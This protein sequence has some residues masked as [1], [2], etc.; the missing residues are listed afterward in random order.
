MK[1]NM[2]KCLKLIVALFCVNIM[3]ASL[4]ANNI[5][6]YSNSKLSSINANYSRSKSSTIKFKNSQQGNKMKFLRQYKNI[7]L[8]PFLLIISFF[9][10]RMIYTE[11]I[12]ECAPM[13]LFS[14]NSL[15][16]SDYVELKAKCI[17]KA[18]ENND[19]HLIMQYFKRETSEC[20]EII[21][22]SSKIPHNLIRVNSFEEW[23]K[24]RLTDTDNIIC[25]IGNPKKSNIG[26]ES[27]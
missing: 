12:S 21:D 22:E 9:V 14:K 13:R 6:S 11:A 3:A 2:N 19:N 16:N 26:N 27:K 5:V 23:K 10:F 20:L 8:L 18:L 7:I 4:K 24:L 15:S 17:K 25:P 1:I